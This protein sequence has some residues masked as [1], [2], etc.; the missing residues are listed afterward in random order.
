LRHWGGP[1]R[2]TFQ[3]PSPQR[4]DAVNWE[5]RWHRTRS[6][7]A[8]LWT[9]R[10]EQSGLRGDSCRRTARW[11][12]LVSARM[13]MFGGIVP[14]FL[15]MAGCAGAAQN[16]A[17]AKP[18]PPDYPP[19]ASTWPAYPRVL[20]H[21][22]WARPSAFDNGGVM[23]AAP[24]VFPTSKSE[25]TPPEIAASLLAR[26]GDRRFV[27]SIRIGQPPGR[28]PFPKDA[29]WAYISVTAAARPPEGSSPSEAAVLVWE[30]AQWE[31]QL[32]TAG[33]IDDFCAAGGSPL[34][35]WTYPGHGGE[36]RRATFAL[37]Q[38]FPNP[39]P[40]AFRSRLAAIGERYGFR[41]AS[42]R[43]LRPRGIA[44][45]MIVETD[46]S[47][48]AFAQDVS[49]ILALVNPVTPAAHSAAWTFEGFYFQARSSKGPFLV[50]AH[51]VR[52]EVMGMH[53]SSDPCAFGGDPMGPP[54]P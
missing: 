2:V 25:T 21:S 28:G 34:V 27:R 37:A 53:W 38:Q 36:Q 9:L 19:A 20:P 47:P 26:L 43:L 22:C 15:V 3:P 41:V 44:P 42:L 54:C 30:Q 1:A 10:L 35:G 14:L 39:S 33:L 52:G 5:E 6:T 24:S 49:A 45:V 12:L 18:I 8:T 46:R 51:I 40:S 16:N 48:K 23:Q 32:V 17:T 7:I 31:L 29:L 11:L 4:G 50:V 13:L